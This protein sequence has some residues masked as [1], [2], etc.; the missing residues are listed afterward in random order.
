MQHARDAAG[1]AGAQ[2]MKGVSLNLRDGADGRLLVYCWAGCKPLAVLAELRHRNLVDLR[3]PGAIASSDG[4]EPQGDTTSNRERARVIWC[5]ATAT[6]GSLVERC[7]AGR[8]LA[9][10][11]RTEEAIRF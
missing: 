8:G 9:L 4:P 1:A 6:R 3:C 10:P 7:L 11:E 5:E 2:F